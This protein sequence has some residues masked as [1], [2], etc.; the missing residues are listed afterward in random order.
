LRYPLV[1]AE[2]VSILKDL[3]PLTCCFPT[4]ITTHLV[5]E[6]VIEIQCNLAKSIDFGLEV[7]DASLLR[8][9]KTPD[10]Q[11]LLQSELRVIQQGL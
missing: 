3:I 9:A 6:Q 1:R 4:A 7:T 10:T 11:F 5:L 2:L 8:V